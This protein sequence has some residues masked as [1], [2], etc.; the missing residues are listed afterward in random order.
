VAGRTGQDINKK[1]KWLCL[2]VTL[3]VALKIHL[4]YNF[5][6]SGRLQCLAT[7]WSQGHWTNQ[8]LF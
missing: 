8:L 6:I 7:L 3:H 5:L 4:S 1:I 2:S